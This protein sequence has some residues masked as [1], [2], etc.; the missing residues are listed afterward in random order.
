MSPSLQK[1]V[2]VL[3]ALAK[4]PARKEERVQL[5]LVE[6]LVVELLQHL[7]GQ[8]RL[9]VS[10]REMGRRERWVRRMLPRQRQQKRT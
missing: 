1:A 3:K 9:E 7:G 6:H 2:M 10:G 5:V 4:G 8:Q